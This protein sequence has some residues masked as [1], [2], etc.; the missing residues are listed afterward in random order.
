VTGRARTEELLAQATRGD[1]RALDALLVEHLPALHAFIRLRARGALARESAT[2]LVQSVCR[3]VLENAGDYRYRGQAAFKNWLFTAALNKIVDRHRFHHRDKR[4]AGR[5]VNAS[6]ASGADTSG[7]DL[8]DCYGSLGATTIGSAVSRREEAERI[9]SAFAEL[10]PQYREVITL[11]RI[12]GLTY[13]EI[14][15][16]TGRTEI[17]VRGLVARGMARLAQLLVRGR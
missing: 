10:P 9:E 7:P 3:E 16:E 13:A 15:A 12:V 6:A 5:E 11:S 8:L 14:G 2:D 1:A 4:D 17:A